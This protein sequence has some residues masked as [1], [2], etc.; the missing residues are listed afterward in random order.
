MRSV[1]RAGS[2]AGACGLVLLGA[3]VARAET[4]PDLLS[5][6]VGADIASITASAQGVACNNRLGNI[7]YEAPVSGHSRACVNGPVRSGNS[8]HSGNFINRGNPNDSGNLASTNGST[9][10]G[11]SVSG[12][13]QGSGNNI[14][15]VVKKHPH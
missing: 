5:A 2:I 13:A 10:S 11:N 1:V 12:A 9:N 8:L 3:G 15:R 6:T 7:N 4:V 14:Q